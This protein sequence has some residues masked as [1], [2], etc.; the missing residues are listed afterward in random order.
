M[1]HGFRVESQSVSSNEADF[2]FPN[3]YPPNRTSANSL[4]LGQDAALMMNG[5]GPGGLPTHMTLGVG[6]VTVGNDGMGSSLPCDITQPSAN[7]RHRRSHSDSVKFLSSSDGFRL[8]IPPST[9]DALRNIDSDN[10]S[11]TVILAPEPSM[12]DPH[13]FR[14]GDPN[15][16]KSSTRPKNYKCSKCG[17][18]KKGHVC[19]YALDK[20]AHRPPRPLSPPHMSHT[21]SGAQGVRAPQRTSPRD[22]GSGGMASLQHMHYHSHQGASQNVNPIDRARTYLQGQLDLNH[23]FPSSF[24]YLGGA[25][26]G[27]S[28][29]LHSAMLHHTDA[30]FPQDQSLA[31]PSS[32]E[33]A[34]D[35]A[36]AS[37]FDAMHEIHFGGGDPRVK[38][39]D[40][41]FSVFLSQESMDENRF[42]TEMS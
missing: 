10:Q 16:G 22:M 32:A 7:A 9:L 27:A 5:L 33:L 6:G 25:D 14:H 23:S 29:M 36:P 41:E 38:Q 18:P 21:L 20:Q 31:M 26:V 28:S 3:F 34:P 8:I 17:Q 39:E 2:T 40:C 24:A 30:V 19:E 15:T 37:I 13:R 4:G 42:R 1:T 12:G 35:R 11:V